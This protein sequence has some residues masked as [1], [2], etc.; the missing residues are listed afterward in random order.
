M[1]QY[2]YISDS[3]TATWAVQGLG[4]LVQPRVMWCCEADGQCQEHRAHQSTLRH[5]LRGKPYQG[6]VSVP[7]RAKGAMVDTWVVPHHPRSA[8]A[9]TSPP[10]RMGQVR[11]DVRLQ[12]GGCRH[13]LRDLRICRDSRA[14]VSHVVAAKYMS[15]LGGVIP[16]ILR[17]S[18]TEVTMD[19]ASL[20]Y[21]YLSR[22]GRV[23]C[24]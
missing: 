10:S 15:Q 1:F 2:K 20:G 14:H 24:C 23:R 3:A 7:G 19:S 8:R 21:A 5:P 18:S 16:E 4:A 9:A 13:L 12:W 22:H 6:V 17:W 11:L